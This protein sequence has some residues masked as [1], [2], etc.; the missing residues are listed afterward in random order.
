M[1]TLLLHESEERPRMTLSSHN[2]KDIIQ[3]I[4]LGKAGL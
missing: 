3:Q 4:Y 2:N 1:I